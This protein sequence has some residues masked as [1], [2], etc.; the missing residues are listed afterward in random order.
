MKLR[1]KQIARYFFLATVLSLVLFSCGEKG[2]PVP[3]P[4][5]KSE[6]LP[7]SSEPLR[8]SEPQKFEWQV[9]DSTT[10][11]RPIPIKVDL[12]SV[13]SKPFYPD[14][15]IPLDKPM[16][17]MDIAMTQDT[18]INFHELSSKP[19]NFKTSILD[20]PKKVQARLP[21]LN[22]DAS[23]G[24]FEFGEDQGLPGYLITAL[25]E[26]SQGMIWIATDKG[27][28]RFDGEHIEIYDIIDE[29][30]TGGQT[31]VLSLL[32]DDNGRIWVYTAEKGFYIIDLQAGIVRNASLVKGKLLLNSGN[33]MIMDSRG[34]IW[35]STKTDG[36][37]IVDPN[38]FSF[39]HLAQVRPNGNARFLVEDEIG[40]I[41]I[42]SDAGLSLIDI[43]SGLVQSLQDQPT[44]SFDF[45]SGLFCDSE[46]NI[47]VGTDEEGIA[48]IHPNRESSQ[49]LGN[50]QGI[51]AP[52]RHFT[53]GK[54]GKIWMSSNGGGLYI[55]DPFK[56]SLKHLNEE[57]ALIDDFATTSLL[58]SQGQIWIATTKGLNLM[59]TEGLM[60][61]FLT[62]ADGL[63]WPNVWSFMEDK[64]GNLWLG[65]WE[66]MDI[67]D[68]ENSTIKRVDL[69]LR[70]EKN[71]TIPFEVQH[72]PS[73]DYL[74]KIPSIG[75][76]VF[77]PERETITKITPDNGLTNLY[78]SACFVD[79]SGKIWTGSFRNGA[80]EVFDP[81]TN[82]FKRLTNKDGIMGDI[83]WEIHEDGLGQIWA[84]TDLGVNIINIEENTISHLMEGENTTARNFADLLTDKENRLWMA[85]R[86]GILIADQNNDILTKI[87]PENGLISEKVYSLYQDNGVMYAGTGNGLTT[88]TPPANFGTNK[89]V[90]DIKSYAKEQGLIFND[91]NA[92]AAIVYNDKL[93]WG[94]D[95]KVLTV[96]EFPKKDTVPGTTYISG[97]AISDQTR[98]FYDYGL[99]HQTY[100]DLDTLF[101]AQKDTFYLAGQRPE[102]TDWLKVNDIGWDGLEGNYNLP[103]N[104]EIP[105]E[106]NYVSFQ[107]TGTQLTNRNKTRYSYYLKGFDKAWSELSVDP[108]SKNY[109]DLPAGSYTFSVRSRS[110]DGIWTAPAEL[111]F[112]IL[113]HWT[114]TWW[115]W[116]L[117]IAAFTLVVG[118]IVQYRS[119][120][121]QKENIILEERVKHR[122]AQLSKSVDDLKST[123]AQ[124]I[125]SE[126]MAS[127]GELTAGIAHEIQNPL[128]FVN[129]FSEV[130]T[131]LLDE[132]TEELVKTQHATSPEQAASPKHREAISEALVI[133]GDVKQ[134]LEKITHHGK[135]ADAI[136]KGML[137][138]SRAGKGEKEP[139][140]LNAL[141]D[142]YLRL[143]YHG[144]RAKD[145]TFNADF[146]TELDPDLPKVNVVPQ[147]IGRVLLNLINNAFQASAGVEHP[148]VTVSTKLLPKGIEI[149]V[150][151]NGHGI[152]DSIK[153]KIFQPFFTTKPTGQ[154]TG[155]GLSLSY[156]IVKAHGGELALESTSDGAKFMI[157]LPKQTEKS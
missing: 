77:N 5:D 151:D 32:E 57:N 141:A 130:S 97:I 12:A 31:V 3:F 27:L 138:H 102:E 122:T 105:F 33:A 45:V 53:E 15:F 154:G 10:F 37:F 51:S 155:L 118:A 115:A 72:M 137:A 2:E 30:F 136:V 70:V 20:P 80:I 13:P 147:D 156:D 59:D 29:R 84:G 100:T 82:T 35:F 87:L 60:P 74:I 117:Y 52:V 23:V 63:S 133:L 65:S 110:F 90:L 41:W 98:N 127:L 91:F 68:S 119:R 76:A 123:Q 73:G 24:I 116:L 64:K 79:R 94:I 129:N 92:D 55:F 134:N 111:S 36:I 44:F 144:L 89:A 25:M 101:S 48:K 104:L 47:W 124:L 1:S 114:N 152:P 62:E 49:V 17:E 96:T 40:K 19:I 71:I 34:M 157:K 58:D 126:K 149:S 56:Q 93:W 121:L 16:M 153:D 42:G 132:A 112:N 125:Q 106:Q 108:Y 83:V 18:V 69:A 150:Q 54:Q 142:E 28:C 66:R 143:S 7:P 109:R 86:S 9:N 99:A 21:E 4:Q 81:K 120:A 22:K 85:T 67:Y 75:L 139:T 145:N 88:F 78:H 46:N 113:P 146:K 8:F 128:N 14:G 103:V 50:A 140:D 6:F 135:R 148:L 95:T 43:D 61:N 38:D 26:D 11:E 39:K 107:F 131:E